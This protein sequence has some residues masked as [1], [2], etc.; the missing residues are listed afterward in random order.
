MS[1]DNF[2]HTFSKSRQN[3]PWPE[4]DFIIEDMKKQWYKSILDIGCGNGRFLEE[5]KNRGYI[6]EGYLGLDS[7]SGMIEEARW[8]HPDCNF[9]VIDMI[10][11]W[12]SKIQKSS[13]DTILLLASFHHLQTQ[14][15]RTRVLCDIKTFLAPGGRIYMTNW[16]LREQPRYE[17]SHQWNGDFDIKIGEYSRYYHGFNVEELE[18]LFYEAWYTIIENRVWEGG[19]NIVSIIL[20]LFLNRFWVYCKR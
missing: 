1:Y 17:K 13:F 3:H 15:E 8:L 2:S 19:R 16:N 5:A 4:L 11:L 12:S 10:S 20:D 18:G 7:S 6:L 14:E 9:D